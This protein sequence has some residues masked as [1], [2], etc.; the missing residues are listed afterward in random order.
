MVDIE[1]FLC[2]GYTYCKMV[3]LLRSGSGTYKMIIPH[4]D[5]ALTAHEAVPFD[6]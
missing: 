6:I 5:G 4:F 3:Q 1:I 2:Y